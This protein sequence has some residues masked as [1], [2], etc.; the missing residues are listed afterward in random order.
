MREEKRGEARGFGF[1][2]MQLDGG[3]LQNLLNFTTEQR[4]D[5]D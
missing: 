4:R 2:E 1:T 3:E 5:G